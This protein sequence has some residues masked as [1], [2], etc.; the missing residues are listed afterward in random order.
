MAFLTI[1]AATRRTH[2]N[3]F[4]LFSRLPRRFDLRLIGTGCN[5]GA[6]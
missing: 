3:G 4:G 5:H 2:G 1:L 6:R